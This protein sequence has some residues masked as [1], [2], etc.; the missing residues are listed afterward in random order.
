SSAGGLFFSIVD[1]K[2]NEGINF[3]DELARYVFI[4]GMPYPNI[5][6]AEMIETIRYFDSMKLKPT[7]ARETTS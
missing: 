1:G 2:M 6:S 7:T 5:G 4:V 3:S